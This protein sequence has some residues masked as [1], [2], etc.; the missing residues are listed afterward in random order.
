[1]AAI[2]IFFQQL[3]SVFMATC[4]ITSGYMMDSFINITGN[5]SAYKS[6]DADNHQYFNPQSTGVSKHIKPHSFSFY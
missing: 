4:T 6:D 3:L 5:K 2:M 1:M